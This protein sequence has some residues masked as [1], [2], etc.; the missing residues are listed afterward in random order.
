MVVMY[1]GLIEV[2]GTWKL[3]GRWGRGGLEK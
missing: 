1:D 2:H 3:L